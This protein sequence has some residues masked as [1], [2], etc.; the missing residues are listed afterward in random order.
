MEM[1]GFVLPFDTEE[2]VSSCLI[3][4]FCLRKP[5]KVFCNVL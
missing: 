1:V 2:D 3:A 5:F 4:S